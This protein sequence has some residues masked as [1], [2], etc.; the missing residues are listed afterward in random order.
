[1]F[2][3]YKDKMPILKLYLAKGVINSFIQILYVFS[4]IKEAILSDEDIY[5]C[6]R[7][8]YSILSPFNLICIKEDCEIQGQVFT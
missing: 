5:A 1:M 7:T 4:E 3:Q 6:D 2:L 8:F